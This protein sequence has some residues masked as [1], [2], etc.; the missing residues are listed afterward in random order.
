MRSKELPGFFEPHIF[1]MT[2][3]HSMAVNYLGLVLDS[4]LAWREHMDAKVRK[5]HNFF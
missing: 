5:A 1:G 3:R 2:L 4:R